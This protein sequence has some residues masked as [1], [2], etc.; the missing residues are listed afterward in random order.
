MFNRDNWRSSGSQQ[1]SHRRRRENG[2]SQTDPERKRQVRRSSALAL[3]G[4]SLFHTE[5][6]RVRGL[7]SR[8]P[9]TRSVCMH[10]RIRETDLGNSKGTRGREKKCE[11]ANDGKDPQGGSLPDEEYPVIPCQGELQGNE[12]QGG[13]LLLFLSQLPEIR[14]SCQV[15]DRNDERTT[16]STRMGQ[17]PL[18]VGEGLGTSPPTAIEDDRGRQAA[19]TIQDTA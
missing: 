9:T 12:R 5:R 14:Q 10:Q 1:D 19:T 18:A 15:P 11:P 7:L 8:R 4:T 3:A 6:S 2:S 17:T 13:R 16:R